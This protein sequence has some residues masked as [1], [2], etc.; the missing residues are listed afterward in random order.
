MTKI[1]DFKN[2]I[3][4]EELDLIKEV[5]LSEG[6]IV[7][8]TETVYGIGANI[9]S[10]IA[11]NKIYE[12][13]GR[14][15]DN[16][17]IVHVSSKEMVNDICL[18]IDEISQQLMDKFWPGPL[19]I[20]L[21]KKKHISNIVSANLDTI[22]VRMPSNEIALKIIGCSNVPI[23]APSANISG[24][25]SGTNTLDITHELTNKVDI[26]ID[27]GDSVIGL[28]STVVKVTNGI[29]N[30][31]RPGKITKEDFEAMGLKVL[32]DDFNKAPITDEAV[33][34]PGTKYKHYAPDAE[35]I[36]VYSEDNEKLIVKINDLLKEN[37]NKKVVIVASGENKAK[38]NQNV[39]SYGSKNNTPEISKNLFRVLRQADKLKPDL[40]II[41]GIVPMGLG[42]AVMNRLIKAA[43]YN[44]IELK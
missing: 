44:Y 2:L 12:A 13:K 24:K 3:N 31:L 8:P 5:V 1:I 28:E 37:Q 26:I 9:Y 10:D 38:Y 35:A 32:D 17:L 19:T 7:M 29:V 22:G 4:Q 20:I 42:K 11:L 30:I 39:I 40:I 36:L 41:E 15:S 14:P 34:S 25:P 43:S 33:L 21:P 23:A 18:E 16:P 6:L 27:G